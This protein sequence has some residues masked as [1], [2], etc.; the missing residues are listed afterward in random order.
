MTLEQDSYLLYI[1]TFFNQMVGKPIDI[2]KI[3]NPSEEDIINLRNRY[4]N[5]LTELYNK[6]KSTFGWNDKTIEI[7]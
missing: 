6:Y 1:R 4:I 7:Y 2:K 5:S 3:E